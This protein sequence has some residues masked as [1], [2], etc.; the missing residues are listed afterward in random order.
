MTDIIVNV[1][2]MS[3]SYQMG[4]SQVFALKKADLIVLQGELLAIMGPSGSGK[5]TFMH[6]LGCLDRPS[7]GTYWLNGVDVS[8]HDD[9]SLSAIRAQYIGF[10]FQSFNLIPQLTVLENVEIPFLYRKKSDR[11]KSLDALERVG[12]KHRLSHRP[13]ELSGGEMQRV[14]IARAISIN[15]LLLLAD[16]PTGNLDYET[17]N[18]ILQLFQELNEQGM[19]II[20]VTHDETVGKRCP[21]II[22]M[23]DGC[24]TREDICRQ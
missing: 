23:Q 19:T 11:N 5:S 2:N 18:S 16:E 22:R 8:L 7:T 17:G 4:Q 10:V 6:L 21:R 9:T 3:K 1:K 14:A 24:I 12:L 15:P 13:T 20:M